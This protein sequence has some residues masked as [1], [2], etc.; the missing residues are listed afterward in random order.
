MCVANCIL[1]QQEQIVKEQN[2]VEIYIY[3]YIYIIYI[4]IYIYVC[5]CSNFFLSLMHIHSNT[6]AHTRTYI[7][8]YYSC[9]YIYI[10]TLRERERERERERAISGFSILLAFNLDFFSHISKIIWWTV[11][12]I[13]KFS[14]YSQL[15]IMICPVLLTIFRNLPKWNH[16]LKFNDVCKKIFSCKHFICETNYIKL[17]A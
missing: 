6:Q 12:F 4:Y 14:I 11:N 9:V 1:C 13:L 3:I 15:Q 10:Y 16:P 2:K 8:M 17:K 5:V 7:Y